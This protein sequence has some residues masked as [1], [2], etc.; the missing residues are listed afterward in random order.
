MILQN[1]NRVLLLCR[2]Q[3]RA[4]SG[5]EPNRTVA[6]RIGGSICAVQFKLKFGKC[7]PRSY[8]NFKNC[9]IF[10]FVQ[11]FVRIYANFCLKCNCRMALTHVDKHCKNM[12][13]SRAKNF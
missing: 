13:L 5:I 11:W 4:W 2:S 9:S 3:W 10:T 1:V 8:Y 6:N 12:N 7:G